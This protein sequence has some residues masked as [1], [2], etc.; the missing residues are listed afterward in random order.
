MPKNLP[1]SAY[2]ASNKTKSSETFVKR[3]IFKAYA[4]YNKSNLKAFTLPPP[5]RDFWTNED[6]LYGRIDP[7]GQPRMCL[8]SNLSVIEDGVKVVHFVADAYRAMKK[9]F[10]VAI[11]K[12]KLSFPSPP[13]TDFKAKKGYKNKTASHTSA[14]RILQ[15]R[16]AALKAEDSNVLS[17]KDFVP[18]FLEYM[19]E[20]GKDCPITPS[21]VS[22]GPGASIMQ[23][24]LAFEIGDFDH[25][26]DE[27]KIKDFLAKPVFEFYKNAA[28]KY[29]FYIDMNAPWR[30]VANLSSPAMQKFMGAYTGGSVGPTKYFEVFTTPAYFDDVSLLQTLTLAAYNTLA[31]SRPRVKKQTIKKGSIKKT[32]LLRQRS[33]VGEREDQFPYLYWLRFYIHLKNIEKKTNFS[34]ARL[35]HIF[36]NS[37][38][39]VK[40]LD[41]LQ[42]LGYINR[43]FDDIRSINGSYNYDE[44]KRFF[45][46]MDKKNWPFTDFQEYFE[47]VVSIATY[48]RY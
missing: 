24:G 31:D 32:T 37:K 39:L 33:S 14:L 10:E 40:S 16:F 30:L 23:S 38:N 12:G 46:K 27:E 42:A 6:F 28:L 2:G 48:K 7:S 22:V 11:F 9:E 5:V 21:S 36:N 47:H 15:V 44:Y 1:L 26:S 35:T 19:K 13:F 25:S 34:E 29:G 45:D 43:N 3:K 17:L 20:I 8:D 4:Y 41:T 18:P